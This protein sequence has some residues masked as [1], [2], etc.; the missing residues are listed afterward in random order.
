M[1]SSDWREKRNNQVASTRGPM[2]AK[3]KH[4]W[5]TGTLISSRYSQQWTWPVAKSAVDLLRLLQQQSTLSPG[6]EGVS[7]HRSLSLAYG[8]RILRK[9]VEITVRGRNDREQSYV[10]NSICIRRC[11]LKNS[12]DQLEQIEFLK[13]NLRTWKRVE[14]GDQWDSLETH[15]PRDSPYPHL[16]NLKLSS[17][18]GTKSKGRR[19][20]LRFISNLARNG[21]LFIL[22]GSSKKLC[23]QRKVRVAASRNK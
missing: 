1:R 12:A 9:F 3:V 16:S 18:L 20:H 2:D 8:V 14:S 7:S 15:F 11:D 23:E 10:I 6:G 17:P 5:R 21:R 13:K 19:F 4:R 22:F